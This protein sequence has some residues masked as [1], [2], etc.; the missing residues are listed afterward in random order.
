MAELQE[1]HVVA[2]AL[3]DAEGRILIAQRPRGRHMAGRW[4]FPGGKL[5][6]DEDP[7]SGLRRE[8]AEELGIAVRDARRLIRLRHDY[9]DRRVWLDVWEVASYEGEPKPLDCQALAWARPDELPRHDLLEA[10]RAIVTAL[11]LPRIARVVASNAELT[12]LVGTI[13]QA[14]LWPLP[15]SGEGGPER[16]AVQAA[17]AAGHRVF[18][19]GDGFEVV[20]VAA[21][22]GCDGAVLHWHGQQLHVDRSGEFL[23]GAHCADVEGALFAVAEGAHF[24]VLAPADGFVAD[25]YLRPL[26]DR[27]GVPVF[28]GWHADAKRL[29][30]LQQAGAHGCA[31]RR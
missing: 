12:G 3:R 11:R 18:V 28:S 20:R 6:P 23:I 4:E 7:L 29:V 17:R 8:L 26:C 27:V 31:I 1:T 9:P 30:H 13:P 22:A 14:L 19:M 10:D 5:G 2:G 21:Q 25:R 16:R 24:L 15:D